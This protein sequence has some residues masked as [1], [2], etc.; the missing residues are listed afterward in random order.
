MSLH[1]DQQRRLSRLFVIYHLLE[2]RGD[3]GQVKRRD[4]ERACNCLGKTIQRDLQFLRDAG[5]S[6]LYDPRRRTYILEKPLPCLQVELQ[7]PDLMALVL[8]QGVAHQR[9]V[10]S[11]L[12]QR[13]L[14][15]LVARMPSHLRDEMKAARCMLDFGENARRDYSAAPL[16]EL[17]AAARARRTVQMTYYSIGRD[18]VDTRKADPYSLTLRN[19]YLSMVAFCHRSREVRLFALDNIRVLHLTSDTF[20]IVPDFSL[21][22]YI[23]GMVGGMRGDLTPIELRFKPEIARWARK[24]RW[25]FSYTQQETADGLLVRGQVSGLEAIRNEVLRWGAGVEVLS[26]PE[27]RR[28]V[29]AE[30][31]QIAQMY[32]EK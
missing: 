27:L 19:G 18:T 23:E 17:V 21:A 12:Q 30:A 8:M 14:N 32:A 28:A 11:A 7:L 6:I 2:M 29:C 10:P 22:R 31:Q 9:G 15:K 16:Q 20:R 26:P 13:A 5:A 3:E 25:E 4:L 1:S 24:I